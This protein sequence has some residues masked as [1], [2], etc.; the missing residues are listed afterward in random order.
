MEYMFYEIPD[1]KGE[2]TVVGHVDHIEVMSYSWGVSNPIQVSPSN[3]GRTMGRPNFGE[4]VLTKKL[5]STSPALNYMCASA[6]NLG[7]T[8]LHLVRQDAEA[9]EN[10]TYMIYEMTD[11]MVSS[12]SIGGSGGDIPMETITI[13]Y[14]KINWL[15]NPQK[16]D[17]GE[18]GVIPKGWNLMT[19]TGSDTGEVE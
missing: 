4:L 14:T 19:N 8:K 2:S 12:V 7:E 3:V 13:S 16:A 6:K 10:L 9:E 17:V 11:T 1:V 18:V 5:D 15:Y